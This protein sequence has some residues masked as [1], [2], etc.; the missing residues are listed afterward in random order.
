MIYMRPKT[1][2]GKNYIFQERNLG[3]RIK[4]SFSANF[5]FFSVIKEYSKFALNDILQ[6]TFLDIL[7]KSGIFP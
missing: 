7:L 1:N 3:F 4:F 6:E 2:Y 5:C